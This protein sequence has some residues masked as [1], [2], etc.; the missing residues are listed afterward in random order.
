VT[1][2]SKTAEQIN[3]LGR[4]TARCDAYCSQVLRATIDWEQVEG[5]DYRVTVQ[6]GT[7]NGRIILSRWPI[8]QILSV[9]VAANAVFPRQWSS[10]PAGNWDTEVPPLSVYGNIAP[11]AA[12]DGGQAIVIPPGWINWGLGRHGWLVRV[13]YINGWPH[14]SL[15]AAVTAGATT[16]PVDDTTGWAITNEWGQTGAAGIVYDS[17]F[18]ET[19]QCTAASVTSGP[20]N[21]T[22]ASPL[23]FSH[24][25]GV[26]VTTL[27]QSVI[28]AVILFSAAEALTR[29]ATSTTVHAIPGASGGS[30]GKGPEDL[31][32]EG[33]LL[34]H[35]LRRTI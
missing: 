18:Q 31:I 16:L 29:G 9:Q 34:L 7:G 5:P 10:L 6:N 27:P 32:G 28:G 19:V 15:T 8:L 11:S 12:I 25:A 14:T 3:I 17:G 4:A 24:N 23:N 33:E 22:I 35:P 13:S 30:G 20:G 2:A 26:M 21:L 1:P